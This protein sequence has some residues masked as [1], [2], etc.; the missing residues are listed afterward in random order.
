MGIPSNKALTTPEPGSEYSYGSA[1]LI[2]PMEDGNLEN[3]DLFIIYI[4]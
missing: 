3:K 2:L 4:I 1:N